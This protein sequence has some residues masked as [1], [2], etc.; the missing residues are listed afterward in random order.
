MESENQVII[1]L[2]NKDFQEIE[3]STVKEILAQNDI[4]CKVAAISS[5]LCVGMNN[6]EEAVELTVDQIDPAE[7]KGIIFIGGPG[8]EQFLNDTSVFDLAKTFLTEDKIV[9]AICW[10]PAMLAKA[11]ILAGKRATVWNG[12]QKDLV[13]NGAT[14][15]GQPVTVDG[16]IITG[17]GP[18]ASA[19]FGQAVATQITSVG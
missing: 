13:Q 11:G 16:N 14:H 3:Y 1:F 7:F 19:A 8:T 4:N 6:T 2:A 18:D 5:G 17:N 9:A 10:A 15:T 12:A